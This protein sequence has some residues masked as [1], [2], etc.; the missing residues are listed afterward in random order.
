MKPKLDG[1]M[2]SRNKKTHFSQ[3]TREMGHPVR[4]YRPIP[5]TSLHRQGG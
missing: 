3:K 5:L 2:V 1:H 4:D